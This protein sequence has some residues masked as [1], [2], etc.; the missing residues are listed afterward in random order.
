MHPCEG[1]II[2]SQGILL[3]T[4]LSA[5]MMIFMRSHDFMNEWP[6]R[7][8]YRRYYCWTEKLMLRRNWASQKKPAIWYLWVWV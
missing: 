3:Q 1:V 7:Y 4:S 6:H 2:G 5:E 8:N